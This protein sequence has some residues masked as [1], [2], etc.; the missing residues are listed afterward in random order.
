VTLHYANLTNGRA[1]PHLGEVPDRR[2]VRVQSTWCEQKRWGDVALT[3]GADLLFHLARGETCVVHDV[4]ERDRESRACW[5]G[6]SWLRYACSVA[7]GLPEPAE[8]V[9]NGRVYVTHYWRGVWFDLDRK[10]RTYLRRFREWH[11][12]DP[13]D[14]RSCWGLA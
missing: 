5:Q 10:E 13:V 6:L 8:Y 1:C 9:R 12:G 14:L 11:A 4:S 7:W 3:V 2:V